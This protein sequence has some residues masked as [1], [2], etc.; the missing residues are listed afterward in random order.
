MSY[1]Y[2][3]LGEGVRSPGTG[4][5]DSCELPCGCWELNLGPLQEQ[6]VLLTTEPLLQPPT[7][8]HILNKIFGYSWE[9]EAEGLQLEG[10]PE[11]HSKF[12]DNQGYIKRHCLK[13]NRAK[14]FKRL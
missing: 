7:K 3:C 5:T 10:Q 11:L 6:H 12:Q 1:L 9:A 13:Q 8:I 4:V 14:L 2:V